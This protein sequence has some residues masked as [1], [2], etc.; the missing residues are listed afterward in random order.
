MFRRGD[1]AGFTECPAERGG[2]GRTQASRDRLNG[3]TAQLPACKVGVGALQPTVS[4]TCRDA[5]LL[6][7]EEGMETPLRHVVP[8][9]DQLRCSG[10]GRVRRLVTNAIHHTRGCA[11]GPSNQTRSLADVTG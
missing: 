3:L 1:P 4:D 10:P 5:Q 6:V 11:H 2:A 8:I 9:S 7:A